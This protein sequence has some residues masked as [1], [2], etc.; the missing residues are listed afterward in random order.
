MGRHIVCLLML[1]CVQASGESVVLKTSRGPYQVGAGDIDG[2]GSPDVVIPCRGEL[3]LPTEKV[4][5]NEILTVYFTAGAS[6]PRVRK[7]YRVGF[8]PYTAIV[9]DIDGD[10][11][12][13]V[14][15]ANFQSN[16]GRDLSILW[17]REGE[18]RLSDAAHIQI[19]GGPFRYEKNFNAE[20]R[21]HYATPGLTSVAAVDANRDGKRDL[22]AVAWSGD[23][24]VVLLNEGSRSFTQRIYPLP[25]GPRDV[26]VADFSGDG[27][28]DLAF[29]IYSSNLVEIW[30]G[31]GVGGFSHQQTFHAQGT[32]PYHLKAGDLDGDGRPDLV[33]GNRGPSD[34]VAV[35]LNREPRIQFVGSFSPGT[36]KQG[37]A[38]A[39]EI[40]EV[41]LYDEDKD[42]H[43]D[44]AAACHL[45][46]KVVRWRG[47]GN[48]AFGKA[49]VEPRVDAFP[50]KGP[51]ALVDMPSG[52]GVVCYEADQFLILRSRHVAPK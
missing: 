27:L 43:L 25:P 28:A 45:S 17:G 9:A 10:A 51:R 32:I 24:F 30:K 29:S 13:D 18:D 12:Q 1:V 22:V 16:D 8:G 33:V 4:P 38:T 47:T 19:Q 40:R 31:D 23:F 52:L 36:L 3:R 20:G 39:D 14:A 44:L 42:G 41:I 5:A 50:G 34:N 49:F 6:E 7:D 35:F 46:H 26:V 21:P 2:D 11:R 48:P 37:E 15:V